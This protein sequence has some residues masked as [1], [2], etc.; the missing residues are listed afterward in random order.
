VE[1]ADRVDDPAIRGAL[2]LQAA[3]AAADANHRFEANRS[4][5]LARALAGDPG[6]DVTRSFILFGPSEVDIRAVRIVMRLG[7][8]DSTVRLARDVSLP[9]DLPIERQTTHLI[10]MAFAYARARDD[11]AAVFALNRV[12]TLSPDDH[13]RREQSA[14][15]P[16]CRRLRQPSPPAEVRQSHRTVRRLQPAQNWGSS[17]QFFVGLPEEG[18]RCQGPEPRLIS[19]CEN[20]SSAVRR[21]LPQPR[22]STNLSVTK[23]H[24][25]TMRTRKVAI[26]RAVPATTH[27]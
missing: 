24:H 13:I 25:A 5:D 1:Y 2:L 15:H 14:E 19:L 23:S 27:P 8:F 3:E 22:H 18:V 10:T 16:V 9:Q 4:L 26:P 7:L 17:S 21:S 12:A 6:T 20:Y 11:V